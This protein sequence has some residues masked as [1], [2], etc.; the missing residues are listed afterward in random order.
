MLADILA[1][2]QR[3]IDR[4]KFHGM[5]REAASGPGGIYIGKAPHAASALD[6]D[7]QFNLVRSPASYNA[8]KTALIKAF[9]EGPE[10][11]NAAGRPMSWYEFLH[12]HGSKLTQK[13]KNE[14]AQQLG[15]PNIMR[16]FG[17]GE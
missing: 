16:Y 15:S 8:E 7:A 10:M 6:P 17:L 1:I 9:K 13:Q 5:L 11:K 3:V 2:N 12:Q 14:I 4:G